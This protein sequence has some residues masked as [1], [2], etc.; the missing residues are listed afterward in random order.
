M[1]IDPDT[2]L[3]SEQST[4]DTAVWVAAVLSAL[5]REIPAVPLESL[6]ELATLLGSAIS[7]TLLPYPAEMRPA[8]RPVLANVLR[9]L[10]GRTVET[11]GV[12]LRF[13]SDL[14]NVGNITNSEVIA[15]G[16][17]ANA[18][19]III[20]S[21]E[22]AYDVTN[23]HNPYLGLAAFTYADRVKYAGRKQQ[24]SKAI[25]TL[26]APSEQR[27]LLFVTGASGSGK[28]SFVRAGVLP[29]LEQHYLPGVQ[30]RMV[31]D[32]RPSQRPVDRLLDALQR[33]AGLPTHTL[34]T[35]DLPHALY[36]FLASYTPPHQV[37][38]LVLDQFEELFTQSEV[39]QR[40]A[41]LDILT[42]LP[43]FHTIRTHIIV[44]LRADYL[45]EI[46]QYATLYAQVKDSIELRAMTEEELREAILSPLH[47][48]PQLEARQK[49]FQ[50]TL[51]Q[52]LSA[53]AA[54]NASYLPLLQFSLQEIWRSGKLKDNAYKSLAVALRT[55]AERIYTQGNDNEPRSLAE[56]QAL[57]QVLLELV[58][59][60]LDENAHRDVR[61]R[62]TRAELAQG[63]SERRRLINELVAARLLSI[64][65]EQR[66]GHAVEV[67]DIIHESLIHN[68]ERFQNEIANQRTV[69][70]HRARFELA[71][72]EWRDKQRSD[73]YLLAGVRLAEAE[74]LAKHG[75]I[76]LRLEGAAEFYAQ[77]IRQRDEEQQR[78][79]E[80]A[81]R[82][83]AVLSVLAIVALLAAG[84]ASWFGTIA[85]RSEVA[86]RNSESTAVA[87]QQNAVAEQRRAEQQQQITLVQQLLDASGN[88]ALY[89]RPA[90]LLFAQ[91][92]YRRSRSPELQSYA[93]LGEDALLSAF[94]SAGR[95]RS[96]LLSD[97]DHGQLTSMAIN[98]EGT[99]I[100]GGYSSGAIVL[101]QRTL[102]QSAW[103][104]RIVLREHTSTVTTLG[105]DATGEFLA[106]GGWD[107][108]VRLW[109]VT[110]G[111]SIA[112]TP[113]F[114]SDIRT[115]AFDPGLGSRLAFTTTGGTIY[116]WDTGRLGAQP[117]VLGEHANASIDSLAF[118][119]FEQMLVSGGRDKRVVFWDLQTG[120][121]RGELTA[122]DVVIRLAFS[123]DGKRLAV[124]SYDRI[125]LWNAIDPNSVATA[126]RA[127]EL[128]A[129]RNWIRGLA[130]LSDGE[131]ISAGADSR[132]LIWD[133][134]DGDRLVNE[135]LA[136]HTNQIVGVAA[137]STDRPDRVFVT[138]STDG[139]IIVWDAV[140]PNVLA[141]P[142]D[143]PQG[144]PMGSL[145]IGPDGQTR[146]IF[147]LEEGDTDRYRYQIWTYDPALPRAT[148]PTEALPSGLSVALSADGRLLAVGTNEPA[149]YLYNE[150][151]TR[152][153]RI[154]DLPTPANG[155]QDD[156]GVWSL[157]M[158]ADGNLLAAGL[159]TGEIVLWRL[160]DPTQPQTDHTFPTGSDPAGGH[161]WRVTHLVFSP[162]GIY[163]ASGGWDNTV[164][165][166]DLQKHLRIGQG[167]NH[168][169]EDISALAFSADGQRLASAAER[170][171][172]LWNV[173]DGTPIRRLPDLH[174]ATVRT[175]AFSPD[176][177]ELASGDNN[178]QIRL[179]NIATGR[180]SRPL[181]AFCASVLGL[182]YQSNDVL[183]SRYY[184]NSVQWSL[185][186]QD[187]TEQIC[188]IVRRNL[189]WDE[190]RSI[191]TETPQAYPCTCANAPADPAVPRDQIDP[192]TSCAAR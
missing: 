73:G 147:R 53:D 13:D 192:A 102:E 123:P 18:I 158:S 39:D 23:L 127:G 63:N 92:A 66:D 140:R 101:W 171:I 41:L 121:S 184:C 48:H 67:V 57:V 155:N 47:H 181:V 115:L 112:Q 32:I 30:V 164:Y 108:I 175:L 76:A 179:W 150:V 126:V 144:E 16:K 105:F 50:N 15:I 151:G 146:G 22:Q 7:G 17:E 177:V 133:V 134:S 82:V 88:D 174:I 97:G 180:G 135:Q 89:T 182:A 104:Q 58:E 10:A 2:G 83:T 98:P 183:L 149:V 120:Q 87:A 99:V 14:I 117:V 165:L 118:H 4:L 109:N 191:F 69:L 94:G 45:P 56:Q 91:E 72:K 36:T 60:S 130:Y 132:L 143:E 188:Q 107:D 24:I 168:G 3:P 142:V 145:V 90:Q 162:D 169:G 173:P 116:T 86:A 111:R 106:S 40:N 152:L 52:R 124:A 167:M 114:N 178:F 59:V 84:V 78:E 44:T 55:H 186:P 163:L 34:S 103:T 43:P 33:R 37:N 77:S 110:Q 79:V 153:A 61:R 131:L 141:T 46:F 62:R 74:A 70:Q 28:S 187:A 129:H 125:A 20:Q 27:A 138:G 12:E 157:A 189:T 137:A 139:Q 9:A 148:Q 161:N 11:E 5:Q 190:W 136:G 1:A 64:D 172:F 119:P 21:Q 51:L 159:H 29:A 49:R 26:T 170:R 100:A 93:Q 176:G 25:A 96:L 185:K 160:T 113:D 19:K 166:W 38:V 65:V 81:R 71:L 75:D 85:Q 128:N 6:S 122:D 80:R 154:D 68:W 156:V 31:E 54:H 35:S 42:N 8:E 95:M